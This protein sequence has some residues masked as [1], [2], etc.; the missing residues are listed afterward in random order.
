MYTV[1]LLLSS[2]VGGGG[3]GWGG[4]YL[5]QTAFQTH[6]SG[7]LIETGGLFNLEETMVT[8]LHEEL[9][10]K[11]EKLNYKKLVCE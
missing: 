11:V 5:F 7:G 3:G 9:E 2:R 4:A 1:N 8:V 6:L 10:H